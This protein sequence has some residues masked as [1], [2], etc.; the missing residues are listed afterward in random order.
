MNSHLPGI[1]ERKLTTPLLAALIVPVTVW[2]SATC[3]WCKYNDTQVLEC[4]I[5]QYNRCKAATDTYNSPAYSACGASGSSQWECRKYDTYTT[6]HVVVY[7]SR[8]EARNCPSDCSWE[9]VIDT[10]WDVRQ[11]WNDDCECGQ[12]PE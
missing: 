3:P 1:L 4:G 5:D 11:C 8:N 10:M 12:C 6:I 7:K 2:A 9:K